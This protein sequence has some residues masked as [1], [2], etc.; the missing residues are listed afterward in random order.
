MQQPERKAVEDYTTEGLFACRAGLTARHFSDKNY[1][2]LAFEGIDNEGNII[3]LTFSTHD[4]AHS[5][6]LTYALETML[7]VAKDNA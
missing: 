6:A 7:E 5:R 2:Y 3:A 4:L 1:Q